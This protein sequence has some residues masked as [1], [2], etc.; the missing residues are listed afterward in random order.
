MLPTSLQKLQQGLIAK[1][2]RTE[3]DETLLKELNMINEVMRWVEIIKRDD[4]IEMYGGAV[5]SCDKCLRP[6]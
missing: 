4:R 3:G 2:D 5:S 1:G 6:F